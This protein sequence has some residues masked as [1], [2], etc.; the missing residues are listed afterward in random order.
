[1]SAEAKRPLP[2]HNFYGVEA[3]LDVPRFEP[4]SAL[5]EWLT[6]TFIVDDGPLANPDHWHLIVANISVLWTNVP[7]SRSGRS[8]VGQ[9]EF[10][11]PSSSMG[12]WARARAEAQLYSWFGG[13]PDFLLTF[14]AQYAADCSDREFCA[15]IEHELYHCGQ[16]RDEYGAPRFTKDGM[17]VFTMRGHDVEQFVGV[18]RRYGADAAHI[19][20]L[21][22]AAKDAPI[23]DGRVQVACGSCG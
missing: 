8:V 11:P 14:D 18:V 2:P 22:E 9:A 13:L 15:L 1:M 23:D 6:S 19:Q 7:N 4:A 20:K 5:L 12:K 16:A 3:T 21:I 10:K 17:P